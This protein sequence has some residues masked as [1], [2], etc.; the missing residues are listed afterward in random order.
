MLTVKEKHRREENG[1]FGPRII[2]KVAK[3]KTI[4][5]RA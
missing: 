3:E 5:I 1:R 4:Q 2:L